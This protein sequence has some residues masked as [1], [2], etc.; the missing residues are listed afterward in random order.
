MS[1]Y[2]HGVVHATETAPETLALALKAWGLLKRTAK[3]GAR[4]AV[5]GAD[6]L[7]ALRRGS[8]LSCIGAC[9]PVMD[10]SPRLLIVLTHALSILLS[11]VYFLDG[12]FEELTYDPATTVLEAGACPPTG[13]R[14]VACAYV[15]R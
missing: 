14:G 1:E 9:S 12:S 8:T 5:P 4:R 2:V 3:S 13:Y 10:M 7:E 6:E 11:A 15:M